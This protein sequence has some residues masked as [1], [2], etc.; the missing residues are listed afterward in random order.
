MLMRQKAF[1]T[2]LL[3][4]GIGLLV[5][6]VIRQNPSSPG[7]T[8]ADLQTWDASKAAA[9][10]DTREQWWQNWPPAKRAQGTFC[11]SCH[12]ALPY[13]MARPML[14]QAMGQTAIPAPE[15][16]LI[17]NIQ[18]RVRNWA[19]LPPYYS[20]HA[21]PGKAAQSR[22]TEAV[23][24][25]VILA[26]DDTRHGVLR[27]V[28]VTA[29]DEAW[30]LQQTTGPNAG[31]WQWQDF[32]LAPWETAASAYQGAALL[33]EKVENAPAGYATAPG[34]LPYLNHL[35]D[36]LQRGYAQQSVMNQLYV[37]WASPKSPQPLTPTQRETLFRTLRTLQHR[38]GG[39]S[40]A[41]LTTD[42]NL[43]TWHWV[44]RHVKF[45]LHPP[46]SDGCATGLV[47]FVL[48]Q[49][50]MSRQDSMLSRGLPWLKQHQRPDGSW[51]ADSLNSKRD[52]ESGV[53]R[54]MS[55]AATG[56]AV[57]ALETAQ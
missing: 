46:P 40:L 10:L 48:Q 42:P 11:V 15:T 30:A 2:L 44:R 27:P 3:L 20:D 19:Q 31:G 37:L 25:A 55:D 18:N 12:T 33:A 38:D 29:F 50:G 14:Q 6:E 51:R 8:A 5:W 16:S 22:A 24:N 7:S 13:A 52:P 32:G 26:S 53:G 54:F 57:M 23:L 35:W 45:A 56:Y 41:Q 21:G 1:I 28:T 9:Y 43:D 34:T 47:V 49:S 39:W 36:Y 17:E 4:V